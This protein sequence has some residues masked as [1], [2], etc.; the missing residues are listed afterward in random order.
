MAEGGGSGGSRG[1]RGRDEGGEGVDLRIKNQNNNHTYKNYVFRFSD[2]ETQLL[3]IQTFTSQIQPSSVLHS[4][5]GFPLSHKRNS[6]RHCLRRQ[7][8]E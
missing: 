4:D 6:A 8:A 5:D 7:N 3:G 2:G 1:W